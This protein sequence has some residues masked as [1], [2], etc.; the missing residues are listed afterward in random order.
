MDCKEHEA[1]ANRCADDR[2]MLW[3]WVERTDG[4]LTVL[5]GVAG[6][7]IL[8]QGLMIYMSVKP[9]IGVIKSASA[10]QVQQQDGGIDR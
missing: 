2:G 3:R 5:L 9:P 1:L 7:S 8:L 10:A 4:K 6:L